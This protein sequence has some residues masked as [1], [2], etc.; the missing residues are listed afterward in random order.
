MR[1][2][3]VDRLAAAIDAERAAGDRLHVGGAVVER[4]HQRRLRALVVDAAVAVHRRHAQLLLRFA[5]QLAQRRQIARGRHLG[6]GQRRLLAQLD[7]GGAI[8]ALAHFVRQRQLEQRRRRR[9]IADRAEQRHRYALL[10]RLAVD[11][12]VEQRAQPVLA[13]PL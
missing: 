3:G 10:R 8:F 9:R 11:Q 12:H 1:D 7:G 2:H 13:E 5:H 6:R 4:R